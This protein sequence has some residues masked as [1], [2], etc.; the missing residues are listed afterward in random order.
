MFSDTAFG[1]LS[2]PQNRALARHHPQN[3]IGLPVG[4]G[5]GL[6][7]NVCQD[8]VPGVAVGAEKEL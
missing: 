8:R 6:E 3:G 2:L 4:S 5:F 1:F 7:A